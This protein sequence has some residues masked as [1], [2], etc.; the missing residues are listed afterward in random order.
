MSRFTAWIALLILIGS[1]WSQELSKEEFNERSPRFGFDLLDPI[2][3]SFCNSTCGSSETSQYLTNLACAIKCPELYLPHGSTT[4]GAEPSTSTSSSTTSTASSTAPSVGSSP[5]SSTPS[6]TTAASSTSA[7]S[8]TSPAS[9]ASP[10]ASTSPGSM[11]S[12]A[13]PASPAS[14]SMQP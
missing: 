7:E 10:G 6:S 2:R 12:P 13:S 9:S 14:S 5:S 1:V 8:S 3:K 4:K 11:T